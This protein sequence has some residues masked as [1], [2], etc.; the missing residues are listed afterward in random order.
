M[1]NE[2]AILARGMYRHNQHSSFVCVRE[3]MFVRKK[4]KKCLILRFL[5]ET[6]ATLNAVE[7]TLNQLDIDGKV[8]DSSVIVHSNLR[9]H[10]GKTF[11]PRTALVLKDECVD[12][13]IEMNKAMS[14]PYT[15]HLRGESVVVDY[16]I[17]DLSHTQH[18]KERSDFTVTPRKNYKPGRRTGWALVLIFLGC[19]LAMVL[20]VCQQ[21]YYA[22]IDG[23][24]DFDFWGLL[25]EIDLEEDGLDSDA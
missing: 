14:G 24:S 4:E 19:A 3:F 10:S 15:Y 18:N 6:D 22:Y 25:S 2:N 13:R 21:L 7:Y 20:S 17:D 16:G 9:A 8:V 5:N 23:S 11:S 1:Y 12:F